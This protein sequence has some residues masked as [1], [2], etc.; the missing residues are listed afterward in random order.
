MGKVKLPIFGGNGERV[1]P[2]YSIHSGRIDNFIF[3]LFMD[4]KWMLEINWQWWTRWNTSRSNIQQ[5]PSV[6]MSNF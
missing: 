2:I 1:I 6:D 4:E 3:T 5:Y